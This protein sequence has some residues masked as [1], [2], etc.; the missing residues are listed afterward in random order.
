MV[1]YRYSWLE[2]RLVGVAARA[3]GGPRVGVPAAVAALVPL[4]AGGP[5]AGPARAPLPPV[6]PAVPGAGPGGPVDLG[7]GVPQRGADVVHLDLVDGPLLAFLGL[8][9]PLP[10]PPRDDDPHPP[11]QRL[12]HVLR[13][14]PPAVTRQEQAVAVL[15]LPG[16]VVAEPGGGS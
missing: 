11:G 12:G 15:P 7:R 10:Q 8:I 16:G 9:R 2:G 1:G 3:V 13:R 4:A 6:S 5:P 14:L